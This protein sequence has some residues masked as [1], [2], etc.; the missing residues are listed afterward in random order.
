VGLEG[1][2]APSKRRTLREGARQKDY[3]GVVMGV[4]HH[5]LMITSNFIEPGPGIRFVKQLVV[6]QIL[7]QRV[8]YNEI[9]VLKSPSFTICTRTSCFNIYELLYNEAR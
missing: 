6:V 7:K 2:L 1:N 5:G 8:F 4:S 3:D 9:G